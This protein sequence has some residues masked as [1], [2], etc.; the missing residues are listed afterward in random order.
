MVQEKGIANKLRDTMKN[1][2]TI[3]NHSHIFLK[4]ENQRGDNAPK[5]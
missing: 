5:L 4:T 1:K 2:Q 3:Q